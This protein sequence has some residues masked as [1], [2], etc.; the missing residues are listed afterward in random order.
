MRDQSKDDS[1]LLSGGAGDCQVY[2]TDV[3]K[4]KTVKTFA[5]HQGHIYSLFTWDSYNFV[6]ASQD[7]TTR[8]WDIRQ[9]DCIHVVPAHPSSESSSLW[10][11][12]FIRAFE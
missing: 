11:D 8:V 12:E 10:V 4:Q 5:G 3:D 7:G 1:M 9:S 6:S 2:L